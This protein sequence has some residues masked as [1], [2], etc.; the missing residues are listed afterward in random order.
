VFRQVRDLFRKIVSWLDVPVSKVAKA[1]PPKNARLALIQKRRDVRV[2]VVGLRRPRVL[3]KWWLEECLRWRG[4]LLDGQFRHICDDWDG[5]P[6]DETC[7][8]FA[9]CS[10]VYA[11]WDNQKADACREAIRLRLEGLSPRS[12]P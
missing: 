3:N 11:D 9:V 7:D 2:N 5:L 8:E 6:V 1:F 12:A 10:C 4:K